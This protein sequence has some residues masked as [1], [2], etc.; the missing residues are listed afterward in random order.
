MS[1]IDLA[2]VL[3]AVAALAAAALL[4]WLIIELRGTARALRSVMDDIRI[5]ARRRGEALN[6]QSTAIEQ[7][8]HRAEGLLDTAERVSARAETLS[9]L[10]YG[11]VAKPVIKTAAVVRGTGRAARRLRRGNDDGDDDLAEAN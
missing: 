7:E 9:K 6:R 8:L 10:T 4:V 3:I 2:A 11:A 5:D 1:A